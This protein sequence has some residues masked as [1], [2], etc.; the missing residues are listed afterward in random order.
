[1]YRAM[2]LARRFDERRLHLQRAGE[3]GTFAPVNGQEAAQV[4]AVRVLGVEIVGRDA[5]ALIA[6]G[7]AA[8]LFLGGSPHLAPRGSDA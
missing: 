5:E 3:I 8:E 6:E 4:G 2:L 7:E 1:M